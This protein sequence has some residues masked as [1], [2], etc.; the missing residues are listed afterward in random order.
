MK[1]LV[2]ASPAGSGNTYASTALNLAFA[3]PCRNAGHDISELHLGITKISIL[4]EP[5]ACIASGSE[6]WL[7][8]SSHVFDSRHK[9]IKG[10]NLEEIKLQ[11]VREE[12]RYVDFLK[13]LKN[14]PDIKL[15]SF[16][17]LTQDTNNFLKEAKILFNKKQDI[18]FVSKEEIFNVIS[19][20]G[21]KNR[22]PREELNGRKVIDKMMQEMYQKENWEAWKIYSELKA[23]LD[24]EGL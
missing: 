7:S 20:S 22:I 9:L 21:N 2:I 8:E 1:E 10:I 23:K 14:F 18:N 6:R 3:F 17:L 19:I 5:F 13:N 15:F 16:E 4:R 24:L 11:I 12:K